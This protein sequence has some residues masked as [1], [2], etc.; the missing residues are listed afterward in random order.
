VSA[1]PAYVFGADLFR[2]LEGLKR[3]NDRS[4]F[5][6][7]KERYLREVRTPSLRF[8]EAFGPRLRRISRSFVADPRPVGGSLFRIHR[9]IRFARDKSP[10]KT[11]VGMHFSHRAASGDAHA[12]GFYL[13]LEPGGCFAAAG[14][15][16]PDG[17]T[18]AKVRRAIAARPAAWRAVRRRVG[19]LEGDALVRPPRGFDPDHPFIEDLKRRD[20]IVSRDLGE[21]DVLGPR[22]LD[23]FAAECRAMSPLVRFLTEA[24][25]LAYLP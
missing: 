8:I 14:L 21:R 24:I 22:F 20:F 7:N 19:T 25:G 2:F 13:H 12:P 16:H 18:A 4:W 17:E 15:W 10:Y 9:D 6:A 5:D 23:R 11:H 1:T 3:H